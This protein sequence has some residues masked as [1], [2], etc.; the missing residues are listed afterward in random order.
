[1]REKIYSDTPTFSEAGMAD[2]VITGWAGLFAPAGTPRAVLERL[3]PI[4]I[5]ANESPD[6]VQARQTSGGTPLNHN[7]DQA[8]EFVKGE[9][10]RWHR[11][12]RESGVKLEM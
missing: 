3:N 1:E 10:E 2:L 5:K 12:H 11:L 8:Q 6:F 7:L 9:I 4:L